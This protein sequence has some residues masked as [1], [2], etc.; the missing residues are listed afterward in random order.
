[1]LTDLPRASDAIK[2]KVRKRKETLR[3]VRVELS[4]AI[5]GLESFRRSAK[6]FE[7]AL[8]VGRADVALKTLLREESQKTLNTGLL[9][10]KGARSQLEL[11]KNELITVY[12]QQ[13]I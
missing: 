13:K 10:L 9:K 1:M 8:S 6:D 5:I 11:R 4:A 7:E 2:I 3:K 12:E